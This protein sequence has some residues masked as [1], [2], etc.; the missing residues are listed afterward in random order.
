[1]LSEIMSMWLSRKGDSNL[2]R[3][4]DTEPDLR[5]LESHLARYRDL[6]RKVSP[7][8]GAMGYLNLIIF[9]F[10]PLQRKLSI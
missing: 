2:S 6:K 7:S 10:A 3:I 5:V 1:M 4:S 8:G 9:L